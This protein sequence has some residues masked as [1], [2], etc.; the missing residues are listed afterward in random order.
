M[1]LSTMRSRVQGYL[2]GRTDATAT[3]VDEYINNAYREL[4]GSFFFDKLEATD[5]SITTVDGTAAYD[6]PSALYTVTHVRNTTDDVPLKQMEIDWYD[7][8]DIT[9][10]KGEP[11]Y[12]VEYADQLLIF[13]TPDDA[14]ALTLRGPKPPTTLTL[15]ADEPVIPEDWHMILVLRSAADLAFYFAM[16]TRGMTLRNEELAKVAMRTEKRTMRRR[17]TTGQISPARRGHNG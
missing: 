15:D 9:D 7:Q 6:V 2:G 17:A 8:Q 14:Y 12:F 16:D 11:E 13:P 3:L 4:T 5:T 1:D 10:N